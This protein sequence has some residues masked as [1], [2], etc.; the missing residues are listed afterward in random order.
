[1]I[2]NYSAY[3][4]E[5]TKAEADSAG[6]YGSDAYQALIA[7]RK[8]F[9]SYKIVVK[10]SKKK[11]DHF[12]GLTFAYMEKYI[13]EHDKDTSIMPVFKT[14]C[15]KG[16]ILGDAR[17]YGEIKMWFLEQ[18]PEFEESRNNI[19]KHLEEIKIKRANIRNKTKAAM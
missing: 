8:D 6:I 4:I 17:S 11:K 16:E 1:M 13:M 3:A 7:A 10:P 12:K 19:S 15:G 5:M 9:P 2:I 18:Y 14:L